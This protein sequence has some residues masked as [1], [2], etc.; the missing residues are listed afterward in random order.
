MYIVASIALI[1]YGKTRRH[2]NDCQEGIF[3]AHTS[4]KLGGGACH[5]GPLG[6]APGAVRKQ[7]EQEPLLWSV[8]K[9]RQGTQAQD[10]LASVISVGS[11]A[12]R[13]SLL[14]WSWS[15]EGRWIVVGV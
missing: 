15:D 13:L 14:V 1:K 5:A 9:A 6:E 8:G 11:R 3:Y 4:L 7:R 12:P 2:E 10:Q